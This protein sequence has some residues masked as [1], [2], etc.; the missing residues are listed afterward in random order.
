MLSVHCDAIS[1]TKMCGLQMYYGEDGRVWAYTY[2][3][4]LHPT[5]PSP[6]QPDRGLL[7]K[8]GAYLECHDPT[9]VSTQPTNNS[10][11]VLY[12]MRQLLL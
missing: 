7:D 11:P 12:T 4:G 3:G 9:R 2:T 1:D 5:R 8:I 10:G 6:I